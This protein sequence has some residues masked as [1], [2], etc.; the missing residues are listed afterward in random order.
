MFDYADLIQVAD[1]LI[2]VNPS[3]AQLRTAA[4]R[5]YYSAYGALRKKI[6]EAIGDCFNG[7]G[8][9]SD[10]SRFCIGSTSKQLQ[11]LGKYLEDMCQLREEADYEWKSVPTLASVRHARGQAA[12]AA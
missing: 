2:L 9:H 7:N 5:V 1:A 8:R 3:A 12:T 4:N 6:V 10:L 11:R